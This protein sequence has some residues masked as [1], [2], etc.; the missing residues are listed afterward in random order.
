MSD[1]TIQIG[2]VAYQY[3]EEPGLRES[4]TDPDYFVSGEIDQMAHTI[5]LDSDLPPMHVLIAT[6]EE[7]IRAMLR[8]GG[9]KMA[10]TLED[11][12]A[13]TLSNSFAD[14]LERNEHMRSLA[15][16]EAWRGDCT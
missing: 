16:F 2:P 15:A 4:S 9:H 7:S 8:Q 5:T 6:W 11:R 13:V 10:V 12:I 14:V 3:I 1:K